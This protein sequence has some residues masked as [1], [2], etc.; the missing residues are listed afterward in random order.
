MQYWLLT[1]TTSHTLTQVPAETEPQTESPPSATTSQPSTLPGLV[2]SPP[3][4]SI[5]I[6]VFTVVIGGLITIIGTLLWKWHESEIRRVDSEKNAEVNQIKIEKSGEIKLLE[7]RKIREISEKNNE[8]SILVSKIEELE[9][10]QEKT[11][12]FTSLFPQEFFLK[13]KGTLETMIEGLKEEVDILKQ[14]NENIDREKEVLRL[15]LE[16]KLSVFENDLQKISAFEKYLSE[17]SVDIHRADVWLSTNQTRLAEEACQL[18]LERNSHEP[19]R[20]KD[21]ID[22]VAPQFSADIGDYL[23][24]IS[25]CLTIGRPNLI[26]KA[27]AEMPSVVS[28]KLY[29]KVFKIIRDEKLPSELSDPKAEREIGMYFNHLIKSFESE[30]S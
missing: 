8:I 18:L 3:K 15:A 12:K 10:N 26:D 6:P 5:L 17:R 21:F 14:D 20:E 27:R 24:I 28:P 4:S 2:D 9:R 13:T 29:A 1:T 25:E 30:S 19:G 22:S 23:T 11:E 7:E 16:Q